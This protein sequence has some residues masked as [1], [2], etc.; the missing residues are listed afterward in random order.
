[1]NNV[2]VLLQCI[3][4]CRRDRAKETAI[5]APSLPV[6]DK[7]RNKL[8]VGKSVAFGHMR[9]FFAEW[10]ISV[11]IE[12]KWLTVAK[13]I[14]IS[15]FAN[16]Q[17]KI[18]SPLQ[19]SASACLDQSF[20]LG[21][22]QEYCGNHLFSR[23]LLQRLVIANHALRTLN[24]EKNYFQTCLARLLF[25]FQICSARTTPCCFEHLNMEKEVR[26]SSVLHR[27]CGKLSFSFRYQYYIFF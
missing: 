23:K 12:Q 11:P 18:P 14:W 26:R 20:M 21:R 1:M 27:R 9:A 16:S 24:F 6:A 4:T 25:D 19:W 7:Q 17:Q 2:L 3:A 10:I 8:N 13:I 5:H 15:P 22:S